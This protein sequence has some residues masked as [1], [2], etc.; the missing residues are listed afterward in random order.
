M[1]RVWPPGENRGAPRVLLRDVRRDS[2]GRTEGHA[3]GFAAGRQ[4][5]SRRRRAREG[6]EAGLAEGR[7]GRAGG[8]PRSGS[9]TEGPR[10]GP[11]SRGEKQAWPTDA[12]RVSPRVARAD[13]PRGSSRDW[14]RARPKATPEAL[15]KGWSKGRP[16]ATPAA[17]SKGWSRERPRASPRR[18][19]GAPAGAGGRPRRR[20]RGR[21]AGRA[22]RGAD[23]GPRR[24]TRRRASPRDA[25]RVWRRDAPKVSSTA[26][27]SDW[28]PD[29]R[30]QRGI[31]GQRP[32]S[33]DAFRAIDAARSLSEILDTL[34]T[35]VGRQASRVAV[36]LVRGP[37]LRAWKS[38]GLGSADLFPLHLDSAGIVR[39]AVRTQSTASADAIERPRAFDTRVCRRAIRPGSAR[40]SAHRRGRGRRRG[41]RRSGAWGRR[42][43]LHA[44]PVVA[45]ARS[46]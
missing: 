25:N 30:K 3:E 46:N 33:R 15:S 32:I 17:S 7:D 21:T 31:H 43:R 39:D 28:S 37:E 34:T 41:V 18:R 10:G 12:N 36:L 14:S 5:G 42:E 13:A 40:R 9:A 45:H 8:R 20:L 19:R 23:A 16:K 38:V 22:G 6:R 24:R 4:E 11:G 2:D 44:R 35:S 26:A 27:R 1:P 29:A